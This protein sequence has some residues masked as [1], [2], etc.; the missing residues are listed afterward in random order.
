MADET[1]RVEETSRAKR[2]N[3]RKNWDI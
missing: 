2:D 3:P 1:K